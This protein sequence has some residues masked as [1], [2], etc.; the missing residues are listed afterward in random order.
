LPT[1]QQNHQHCLTSFSLWNALQATYGKMT[2]SSVFRDFKDC[3]NAHISMNVDL[4]IYFDKVFAGY[5]QMKAAD[6]AVP[7]QLQAMITLAALP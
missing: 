3:L 1:I 6:I 7:P 2:A 4:Q 5:A